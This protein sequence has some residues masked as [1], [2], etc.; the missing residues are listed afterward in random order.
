MHGYQN[1]LSLHSSLFIC[2]FVYKTVFCC[3]CI[4]WAH[5]FNL[6]DLRGNLGLELNSYH[7]PFKN[8]GAD[9]QARYT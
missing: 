1:G 7:C 5:A 8:A 3:C 2:V 9:L 6:K 4:S